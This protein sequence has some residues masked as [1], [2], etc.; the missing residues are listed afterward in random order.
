M[1]TASAV[2]FVDFRVFEIQ[3]SVV[4]ALRLGRNRTGPVTIRTPIAATSSTVSG[5]GG[6]QA[7]DPMRHEDCDCSFLD[8]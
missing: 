2:S 5:S 6:S 1:R 4:Q 7:R 3:D 8:R